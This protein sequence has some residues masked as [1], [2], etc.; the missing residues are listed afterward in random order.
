MREKERARDIWRER[1]KCLTW[2]H[3]VKQILGEKNTEEATQRNKVDEPN[4]GLN[5]NIC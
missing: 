2:T 1:F 4:K 5:W 3:M